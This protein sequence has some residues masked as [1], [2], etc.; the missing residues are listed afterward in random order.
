MPRRQSAHRDAA[1]RARAVA[2]R[3]RRRA[4]ARARIR[5]STVELVPMTTRGDQMLDRAAREIG[6]KGLFLKELEVAMLERR[7]DIAVHSMKDVPMALE[8][9]FAIAAVLERADPFDAFVSQRATPTSTR[10]RTARASAPR[11]CA[12]RRSCARCGPISCSSTCA[13][14]STRGSR[15]LDAG[16]VRRDRARVRG[17]GAPGIRR[18]H[19][20]AARGAGVAAGRGAG[21]DRHRV[22]RRR[23]ATRTQLLAPLA[24]RDHDDLRRGRARDERAGCRAAA[25]CRSPPTRRCDGGGSHSPG[26]SAMQRPASWCARRPGSAPTIPRPWAQ[27][28]RRLLL[29]RGA[30]GC[31]IEGARLICR[32]SESAARVPSSGPRRRRASRRGAPRRRTASV[33]RPRRAA[34]RERRAMPAPVPAP[35]PP[36]Q[37]RSSTR[38]QQQRG[39]H[40]SRA[41]ATRACARARNPSR[42]AGSSPR[43]AAPRTAAPC[44]SRPS[45]VALSGVASCGARGEVAPVARASSTQRDHREQRG[46]HERQPR[47]ASPASAPGS[48]SNTIA[49]LHSATARNR[50]AQRAV[51]PGP[52]RS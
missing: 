40:A 31:C 22:P 8:P 47:A 1:E 6:G 30:G 52:D 24:H 15:K 18:A 27:R 41:A 16:R 45:P 32:S 42:A 44:R 43:C 12:G 9:E 33:P 25:R 38:T 11:R 50:S 34:R 39:D 49:P 3:A 23:R 7:A 26:W 28:S 37:L 51:A 48:P 5:G 13:A 10:C 14:T 19:P 29:E 4:A 36:A 2:G 35:A 21:R 17:A 46:Q 20:R